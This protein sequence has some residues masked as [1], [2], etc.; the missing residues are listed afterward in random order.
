LLY[1]ENTDDL[2]AKLKKLSDFD[3]TE[4]GEEGYLNWLL[5]GAKNVFPGEE[6]KG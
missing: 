5:V 6:G 4:C 1:I 2:S 3:C